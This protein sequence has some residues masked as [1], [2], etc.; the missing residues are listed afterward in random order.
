MND[1][2][3]TT[4]ENDFFNGM[5]GDDGFLWRI[6][7]IC[8]QEFNIFAYIFFLSLVRT[9]NKWHI[10]NNANILIVFYIWAQTFT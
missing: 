2:E 5:V 7:H 6:R 8:T 9:P 4:V 1:C 3:I 10:C